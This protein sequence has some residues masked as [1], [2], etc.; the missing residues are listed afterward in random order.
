M[1]SGGSRICQWGDG[2]DHGER[3][4]RELKQ[5]SIWGGALSG[6]QGQG[7]HPPLACRPPARLLRVSQCSQ[8]EYMYSLWCSRWLDA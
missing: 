1:N 3:A 2:A 5:G 6:V 8:R 7:R 4:K